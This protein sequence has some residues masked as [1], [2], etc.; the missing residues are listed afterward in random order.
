MNWKTVLTVYVKTIV[1]SLYQ[2]GVR[3]AVISPGSRSTPLAYLFAEHPDIQT[4]VV[5][6]ERS[7]AFFAMGMAKKS[8][9]PVVLLCTSGSAAANYYP[10]IVEAKY[11]RVPLIALTADRPH[12]L[13]EVGAPQAIDQTHLYGK[14]VKWFVDLPQPSNQS[15]TISYLRQTCY[16]AF[17]LSQQFPKGPVHLNVP[18]PEPL[19]P[20]L[21][22]EFSKDQSRNSSGIGRTFPTSSM[23][24]ELSSLLNSNQNG[25][26]IVGE[27]ADEKA[28]DWIVDLSETY[29][30]PILADPLSQLR[31]N[32]DS[33]I[34]TLIDAYDTFLRFKEVQNEVRPDFVIRFGSMPVSKFLCQFMEEL[35]SIRFIVIDEGGHRDPIHKATDTWA[36]NESLLIKEVLQDRPTPQKPGKWAK[37]WLHYNQ[38][39]RMLI[40]EKSPL[41]K[42][43]E[44]K[45]VHTILNY[46]PDQSLL[47]VG[48]SMPIRDVDTFLSKQP[49]RVHVLANR[50]TNG[51]DGVVSSALGASAKNTS[52]YLLIG[53]LSFYHDLNGLLISQMEGID[54]TIFVLNNN[55]GG[56]FSF[57]PQSNEPYHFEKLFGTPANLTFEHAVQMYKGFYTKVINEAELEEALKSLYTKQGLKVVEIMT[58]REENVVIHRELWNF[59]SRE[60]MGNE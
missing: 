58:N 32:G 4:H 46:L 15:N 49:K 29:Q 14:H 26:I 44:G 54:I 27:I 39:T 35:E 33:P 38:Q 47:Y 52:N 41:L 19:I 34:Q 50:G 3:D 13:R 59:V 56:I 21:P 6:D 28:A 37:K 8:S 10:A 16:K 11:A 43:N 53:D 22:V 1:E 45:A 2:A 23:V 48:N 51:I 7:A 5:I 57:L 55:G 18:L 12:E 24:R 20:E 36:V 40:E 42:W 60:M 31:S 30:L 9:H 17:D 25:L